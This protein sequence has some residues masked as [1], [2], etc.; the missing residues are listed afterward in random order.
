MTSALFVVSEHGYWG[1]EC[2]EPL[3]TLT[4]AGLDITVATPTGE[5][6]VLDERSV[7]PEE[8]GEDL[9]E[10]VREVHETDERL[11]NPIPLAQAD[12]EDYD[13][14][15]FP[16]GHGAEWDV[17]QDVH[18]RELLRESVAGD[19]GKALVVCHTVGIL[20]FTRDTDGEFLADGRSVTGFPNA[21]EEGIVDENDLLPDG[22]KLPYWVEDEVKAI[23]ADWDAELDADTSVTVDGDLI[24]ARGPPSSAAAA[25][26]LLDELGIET[27]A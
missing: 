4:E 5:P 8:V 10:H 2:I 27:S 12:A 9:S 26:T 1:E 15:V 25:R 21:W 23:G 14:V 13:T 6:P 17:T 11:N 24:T 18:A 20:A 3:T 7:D 22:R 16:G 19:D